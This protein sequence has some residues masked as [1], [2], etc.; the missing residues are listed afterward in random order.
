[1]Y[2]SRYLSSENRFRSALS[3]LFDMIFSKTIFH[4]KYTSDVLLESVLHED[5]ESAFI[6]L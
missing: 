1:M 6:R 4:Q 2:K 5:L 3:E